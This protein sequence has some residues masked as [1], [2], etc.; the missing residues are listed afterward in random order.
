MFASL[1]TPITTET[2]GIKGSIKRKPEDFIVGEITQNLE[3]LDPR[4]ENY[5]LEG[6]S[7]LFLYFVLIK[8]NI[9]T[10]S[11]LDWIAKIWNIPRKNISIAGLK[12]KRAL[13]AQRVSVWGL[14]EK[15]EASK[16]ME[17]NTPKIRTRSL[18]LRLKELRLGDLWGNFFE[19]T[20]RNIDLDRVTIENRLR[21]K[22]KEI[23]EKGNILN[24]FGIQRFG[25][26]RPITHIV[27]EKLLLGD[28]RLAIKEYVGRVFEQETK[29]EVEFR[30]TYWETENINQTLGLI[31]KYLQIENKL[32]YGLLQ[33]NN[34]YKQ[35][36]LSLPLQFRKLFIHA[37]QSYLFN[38]Y[39]S[40][41]YSTYSKDLSTPINGEKLIDG[42]VY[43][44]LLGSKTELKGDVEEIYLKLLEKERV[45]LEDF[46]KPL[47]QKLGG[48]GTY[49][50]IRML[51][52][53]MQFLETSSDELNE[54][55]NKAIISFHLRRGMYAT[56]LLKEILHD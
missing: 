34:D 41:R 48:V 20:I 1:L 47:S 56:E 21:N 8:N 51:F 22:F 40:I 35:V 28:F 29:E 10:S 53:K 43:A 39:L 15:F 2:Q 36:F 24:G 11:A 33:T 9:D 17:I 44:P 7:G 31:P 5:K 18:C 55:K 25:E 49:R 23:E 4:L 14:K 19:I 26:I 3:V 46:Y 37:Y 30:R 50:P 13:T 32:L 16:I 52:E 42:I 45:S 6:K 12:D 27:G 38:K 54:N